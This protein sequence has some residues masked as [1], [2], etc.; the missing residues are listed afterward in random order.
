MLNGLWGVANSESHSQ[1]TSRSP[2]DGCPLSNMP[3]PG[4][5]DMIGYTHNATTNQATRAGSP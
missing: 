2:H 1:E 4:G 5:A 3:S